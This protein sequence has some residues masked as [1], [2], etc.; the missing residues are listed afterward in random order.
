MPITPQSLLDAGYKTYPVKDDPY[1]HG[2]VAYQK[3]EMAGTAKLYFLDARI[4]DMDDGLR[5]RFEARLYLDPK[6]SPIAGPYGFTVTLHAAENMSIE[7]VGKFFADVHTRM[8]C[9]PDIHN[10]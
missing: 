9:Q 8:Q 4:F 1:L 10:D 5:I 3:V 7:D 6:F 2:G